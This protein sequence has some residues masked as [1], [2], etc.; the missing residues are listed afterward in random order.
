[1]LRLP[2]CTHLCACT[3]VMAVRAC[4]RG[5]K[6]P[7]GQ[8][9]I[10][11]QFYIYSHWE[12]MSSQNFTSNSDDI[13]IP[14]RARDSRAQLASHTAR[15]KASRSV[16]WVSGVHVCLKGVW[17]GSRSWSHCAVSLW[18]IYRRNEWICQWH[19]N[20]GKRW[21][22]RQMS[23]VVLLLLGLIVKLVSHFVCF[24]T[25][26]S[27]HCRFFPLPCFPNQFCL[28]FC[29]ILLIVAGQHEQV[30]HCYCSFLG[31]EKKICIIC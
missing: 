3:C 11:A 19:C 26:E 27:S 16:P 24:L 28:R 12:T 22:Q 7:H 9:S 23:R 30:W 25:Q 18:H 4:W 21:K 1:M 29:V 5:V 10:R 14:Y 8:P 15:C 31:R 2:S 17:W 6:M 20:D 13:I